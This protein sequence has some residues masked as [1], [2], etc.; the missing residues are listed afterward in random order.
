MAS[1]GATSFTFDAYGPQVSAGTST[2]TWDAFN[3]MTGAAGPGDTVAL[4][5]EG[6]SGEVPSDSSPS[7]SRNPAGGITRVDAAPPPKALPLDH[8]PPPLSRPLPPPG[9]PP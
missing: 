6:M 3:R 9:P 5:Y 1:E 4:T 7:Y 2:S 8:Q